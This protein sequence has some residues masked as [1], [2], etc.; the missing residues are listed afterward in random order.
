MIKFVNLDTNFTFYIYRFSEVPFQFQ[1]SYLGNV[2]DE[3]NTIFDKGF[4][5][6]VLNH[7]MCLSCAKDYLKRNRSQFVYS[8][9]RAFMDSYIA[10]FEKIVPVTEFY[11][12]TDFGFVLSRFRS[13]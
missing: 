9:D 7:G 10:H 8:S 5:F 13:Y 2:C 11:N 4:L 12:A 3:C 1:Y 6:P